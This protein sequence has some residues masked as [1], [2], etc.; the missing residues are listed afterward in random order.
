MKN[1]I[2]IT[3]ILFNNVIIDA[4]TIT[5]FAGSGVLG[6]VIDGLPATATTIGEPNGCAF[7]SH[8]NFYFT[9]VV[10]DKVFKVTPSG[11]ISAIAGTSST[12]YNGDNIAATLAELNI[13][14]SITVD[15]LDNIYIA[16]ANNN[17]VR[18]I[19][20][21]TGIITTIAGTGVA[22][23][24]GDNG[25]AS[26]AIFNGV[27]AICFDHLGNMYISDV[28]NYRIRKI[29]ISGIISTFAGTGIGGYSGDGGQATAAELVSITGMCFDR[30]GN[31]LIADLNNAVIRMI[32]TSG[33]ITTIA[34]NGLAGPAGDGGPATA[35]SLGEFDLAC[36]NYGNI[37]ISGYSDHDVRL[38][39]KYGIIHTIAGTSVDGYSGDNGLATAAQLS[40][41]IGVA[42]DTCGNVYV[43]DKDNYRIRKIALNPFCIPAQV[44]KATERNL[45]SIF[46]NPTVDQLNI[47][48]LKSNATYNLR[49]N[50]GLTIQQGILKKGDNQID[51]QNIPT[52]I[53]MLEIIDEQK[54]RTISKIIKQ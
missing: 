49:N 26:S 54:N 52:G 29:N 42:L 34:G 3:F 20:V 23:F 33:I 44:N 40:T 45:L 31:L 43:A 48:N 18:K 14:G 4:Q 24:G 6:D 16:D 13:P 36:D 19:N 17:R 15:S 10:P 51:I 50:V 53:Y 9:Q 25:P 39:D 7:D 1:C 2:L 27:Q 11:I 8:G 30:L 46:P 35:A 28:G 32:K 22:S 38:I 5:T 12:G 41:T 37:F 47:T 21:L